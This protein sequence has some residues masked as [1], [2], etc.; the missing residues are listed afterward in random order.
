MVVST[1]IKRLRNEKVMLF[2]F[3]VLEH[4]PSGDV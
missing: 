2:E 3:Q 4:Y 1:N